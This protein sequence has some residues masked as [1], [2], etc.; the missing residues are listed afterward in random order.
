[1]KK[2]AVMLLLVVTLCFA[3]EPANIIVKYD[4]Y[5][6]YGDAVMTALGNLYPSANI[7]GYSGSTWTSFTTDLT[8]GTDWDMVICEAH[9]YYDTTG[10]AYTA[11]NT[12][13]TGGEG[14]VFYAEWS[15]SY[16]TTLLS[17]MGVTGSSPVY[18]PPATHYVWDDT[19]DITSGIADWTYSDPGYGTGGRALTVSDATPVTGWTATETAGQGGICVAND[20]YSVASG[21]FPSLKT[22]DAVALWEQMLTFMWTTF[23]GGTTVV[24]TSWGGIKALDQ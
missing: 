4:I 8:G 10:S 18:M 11:M 21:Y 20:G 23:D 19:H 2:I 24:N 5:G 12:Y 15:M 13:Y 17:S 1:M 9:N 3:A 22:T 6:G 14:P 16:A 7:V